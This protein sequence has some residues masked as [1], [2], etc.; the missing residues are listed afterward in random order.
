[1]PSSWQ[2]VDLFNHT[3]F[4]HQH[5]SGSCHISPPCLGLSPPACHPTPLSVCSIV[6]SMSCPTFSLSLSSAAR[7][8]A[9]LML[10]LMQFGD[11][12]VQFF[13]LS[14]SDNPLSQTGRY[15][16][17]SWLCFRTGWGTCSWTTTGFAWRGS[18]SSSCLSTWARSSPE[19]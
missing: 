7:P 6:T 18:L 19:G 1:M 5:S 14:G 3:V 2:P 8:P 12:W 10:P 15:Q 11:S 13:M 16:R 17:C 9:L 4:C